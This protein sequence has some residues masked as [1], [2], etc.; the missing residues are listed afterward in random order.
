LGNPVEGNEELEK[1]APVLRVHPDVLAVRYEV[2]SKAKHWDAAAEI[3]GTQAKLTPEEPGAWISL[4]YA[5]R[6]KPGGGISQ[7][8]EI[9]IQAQ[10]KFPDQT[11]ISYNLACYECQL[12]NLNQAWQWLEK[13][14]ATSDTKRMK[15]MALED[16]DLQPL[17]ERIKGI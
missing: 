6:H 5:I 8:R 2:Y 16:S 13:A 11:L 1:I 3:A 9:L 17:W 10:P 7:A 12:G 14:F 4:A 15:R